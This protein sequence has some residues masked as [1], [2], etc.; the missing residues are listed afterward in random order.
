MT[1]YKFLTLSAASEEEY[2][3][4][5]RILK[6]DEQFLHLFFCYYCN[7]VILICNGGLGKAK[8]HTSKH[9]NTSCIR[10][11]MLSLLPKFLFKFSTG[12][13]VKFM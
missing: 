4:V 7:N 6:K 13:K 8:Q 5:R 2:I 12:L 3:T 10:R 9:F 11:V 1:V